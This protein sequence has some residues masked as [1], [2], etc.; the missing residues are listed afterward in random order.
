MLYKFQ[1]GTVNAGD[2][3]IGGVKSRLQ[4]LNQ[5][6]F[7]LRWDLKHQPDLGIELITFVLEGSNFDSI[8]RAEDICDVFRHQLSEALAEHMMAYCE[9]QVLKK[10]INRSIKKYGHLEKDV[11]YAKARDILNNC[12]SSENLNLLLRFGR[13]NRISQRVLGHLKQNE[14]LLVEGFVTFCLQDYLTEIKYAAEV[15]LE[16]LKNER[17]YSEFVSLLR[18][19]VDSQNPKIE[20]V[21]LMV[22][23]NGR[24]YLWDD[25]GA[26][27][28]EQ[29]ISYYLDEMLSNEVSLDDVL[30]SILITISPRRII[31]H[32]TGEQGNSEPV[33]M[34]RNVFKERISE[35][36]GCEK[37]QTGLCKQHK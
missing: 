34:I 1:V 24:F 9:D 8:F 26:K 3:L 13:K 37:C 22:M 11:V 19:F 30:V 36:T 21:N 5:K 4:W 23:G 28:D 16:E 25:S 15:A 35:C 32:N 31:L 20:E 14:R 18:Y 29:Y 12:R 17:E 10:E 7:I 2:E 33:L 6:G 27:I